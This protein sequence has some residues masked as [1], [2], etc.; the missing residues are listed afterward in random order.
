M[1]RYASDQIFL[2]GAA[3]FPLTMRHHERDDICHLHRWLENSRGE[4]ALRLG[5]PFWP[6]AG[7]GGGAGGDVGKGGVGGVGRAV[8]RRDG[9]T[10]VNVTSQRRA[11]HRRTALNSNSTHPIT[12]A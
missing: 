7:G 1:C 11:S 8:L 6:V 10:R 12:G 2:H 3:T 5:G 9:V 4:E